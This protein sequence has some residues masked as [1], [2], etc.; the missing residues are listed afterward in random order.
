MKIDETEIRASN[1]FR[2]HMPGFARGAIYFSAV[3]DGRILDETRS[4]NL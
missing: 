1:N 3:L 4:G 2:I